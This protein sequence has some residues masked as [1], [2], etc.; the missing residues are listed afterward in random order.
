VKQDLLH[1][2]W[3]T[4]GDAHGPLGYGV[5]AW[6][7]EDAIRIIRGFGYNLPENPKGVRVK[8]GVSVADLDEPHVVKN[9]GPIVVRGLWY[10]FVWV[11]APRWIEQRVLDFD[12]DPHT[13]PQQR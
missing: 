5:T 6:S 7:L 12:E 4:T 11:G 1:T 10:P 9:M 3:I 2:Y 8:R 13:T